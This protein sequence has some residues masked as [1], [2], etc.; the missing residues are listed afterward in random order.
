MAFWYLKYALIIT[1]QFYCLL[2]DLIM[3]PTELYLDVNYLSHVKFVSIEHL[4]I[5]VLINY[6][7]YVTF[8]KQRGK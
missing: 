4:L 2:I 5:H 6:N 8:Q 7:I 3:Q 1:G